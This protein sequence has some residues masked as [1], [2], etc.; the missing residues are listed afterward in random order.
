[1]PRPIDTR[2]A[3]SARNTLVVQRAAYTREAELIGFDGIPTLHETLDALVAQPLTWLGEFDGETLVGAI[4][5]SVRDDGTVDIDRLFVDPR[6]AR[7]GHA[8]ELVLAVLALGR[9][10]IVST[11]TR[12]EPARRLYE[13]LGF[14]V[15]GTTTIADGVTTTQYERAA[16]YSHDDALRDRL[17]AHLAAHERHVM[18]RAARRAAVAL[19]L[20]PI[21]GIPHFLFT[22]RAWTLRR[23]A[24]QYALPGGAID[25]GEDAIDA[26][27]RELDEELGVRLD[28]TH[29]LGG[30]DDFETRTDHVVTPVVLWS[31]EPATLRP[32][33]DEVNQAWLVPLAELDRPDAPRVVAHPSGGAPILRM[34]VRGEWINPPTAA[35][36]LQ[37]RD[38][39]VHGRTTRVHAVGQPDWT[40]R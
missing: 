4:A 27:V 8:R 15:S 7:R 24:G 39:A 30:L 17:E 6:H 19:A 40:A 29:A 13:S 37:L 16:P 12:N 35:F 33:A 20:V 31:R 2:D 14:R 34:P 25:P 21:D 26:A 28:R 3:A 9:R 22:Q 18:V 32:A 38:V 11:G 36:L 5:W 1:M 23:G 10:T